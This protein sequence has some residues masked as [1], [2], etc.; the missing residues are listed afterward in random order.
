MAFYTPFSGFYAYPV[1]FP[2]PE[3]Y[4]VYAPNAIEMNPNI[5][6]ENVSPHHKNHPKMNKVGYKNRKISQVCFMIIYNKLIGNPTLL[7]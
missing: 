4:P 7:R 2:Q 6:F 3:F 5:C 1:T